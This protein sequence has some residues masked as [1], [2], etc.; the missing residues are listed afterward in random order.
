MIPFLDLKR[1]NAAYRDRLLDRWEEWMNSGQYIL[2]EYIASFEAQ[3]ARYTGAAQAVG[4]ANGSD[5]IY[6]LL[7]ACKIRGHLKE[8]DKV[9]VPANTYIGSILPVLRA[10]LEPVPVEPDAETLNVPAEHYM[11]AAEKYAPR[12]VLAVHLYG[13]LAVD[14]TLRDWAPTAG[15]CLLE[16]AAQAH[17]AVDPDGRK[18]GNL[19]DAAAWSFYPTKNLGALGD[20]G[21]ITT[22]DEE[23]AAL[24]RQLRNY[25]QKQK[26]RSDYAGI[27]A[28]LDPVQ[29]IVLEL[30]L[31]DLDRLNRRRIE[32]AG[33]YAA[34]IRHPL[35]RIPIPQF[36]GSHVYH[37]F[38]VLSPRRDELQTYLQ[39][40]G[41]GTLIHYPVPPH[42]QGA[43]KSLWKHYHLP[44]TERIHREILSLPVDPMLQNGE[45]ERIIDLINKFDK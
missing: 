40:R 43:L 9:L 20:A 24:V 33:K 18:A 45:V 38:V 42:R 30:K 41:I 27:N 23:M 29:A 7:E 4:T 28:R 10:G 25:G 17:G 21:A 35:V 26:Y 1:L 5:A 13:R 8:G 3:W 15:L 11:Q 2:G 32:I 37:Q 36:D 16:D 34:G 14:E 22:N 31:A 44:L 6:L 39:S 19:A 12:A